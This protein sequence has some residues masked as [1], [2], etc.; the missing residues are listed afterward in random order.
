MSSPPIVIPTRVPRWAGPLEYVFGSD[1]ARAF[2][3]HTSRQCIANPCCIWI[4][5]ERRSAQR[6][7]AVCAWPV[8][9][10]CNRQSHVRVVVV[11]HYKV[12]LWR[13]RVVRGRGGATLG[14]WPPRAGR[15]RAIELHVSAKLERQPCTTTWAKRP[16]S[17]PIA[18]LWI[19]YMNDRFGTRSEVRGSSTCHIGILVYCAAMWSVCDVT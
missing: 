18:H 8:Q 19:V 9:R 7:G 14:K 2:T 6:I 1:T 3:W 17:V 4:S 13:A 11:F 5:H 12:A 16:N 15:P 10:K